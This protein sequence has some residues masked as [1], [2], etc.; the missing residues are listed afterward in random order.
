VADD[1]I[2]RGE[3]R[4][5]ADLQALLH[6][7]PPDGVWYVPGRPSRPGR[8]GGLAKFAR[9]TWDIV[10]GRADNYR[11]DPQDASPDGGGLRSGLWLTANHLLLVDE[12]GPRAVRREDIQ[13]VRIHRIGR[14]K[15]DMLAFELQDGRMRIAVDSLEGWAGEAQALCM[16]VD[17]RQKAWRGLGHTPI[18]RV[19]SYAANREF[20]GFT[21]WIEREARRLQPDDAGRARLLELTA[22]ALSTWPDETRRAPPDWFLTGGADDGE[23]R[24]FAR[25]KASWLL[26]LARAVSLQAASFDDAVALLACAATFHDVPLTA[27]ELTGTLEDEPFDALLAWAATKPLKTLTAPGANDGQ[28][29]RLADFKR[30]RGIA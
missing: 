4:L 10:M 30:E 15:R 14:A 3:A 7:P 25:D 22:V 24:R 28:R 26:P 27:I 5:P 16:E 18:E 19:E 6:A 20:E 23:T 21:R 2:I 11:D 17:G 29:V 13:S 1:R 12:R 9:R 8:F